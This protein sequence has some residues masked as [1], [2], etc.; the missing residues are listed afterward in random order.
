MPKYRLI[1]G[2][3]LLSL[4][5][6]SSLHPIQTTTTDLEGSFE[7]QWLDDGRLDLSVPPTGQLE[8]QIES[9]KSGNALYDLEMRRRLD[10]RRYPRIVARIVEVCDQIGQRCRTIGEVSFHGATQQLE[11]EL[12]IT[13]L[14]D[15]RLTIKG[16]ITVDIRSFNI[17]PPKLLTVKVFPEVTIVLD[18]VAEEVN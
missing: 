16:D 18:V 1:R 4:E 13:R 5:A 11:D 2:P 9:L 10:T 17:E 15:G 14:D 8:V 3:S 12:V 6:R 7:A